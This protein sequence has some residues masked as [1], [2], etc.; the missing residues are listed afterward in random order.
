MLDLPPGDV[1]VWWADH[2]AAR[3]GWRDLLD[4][5]ER[6]RIAAYR[7][8]ADRD[9]FLVGVTLIRR[10]FAAELDLPPGRVSLDRACRHCGR[11]HGKVR[12]ARSSTA[13]TADA[14]GTAIEVSLSHSGAWVVLAA[15]RSYPVGVD[16]ETVDASIDHRAVAAIVLCESERR[17]LDATP[18]PEW[19]ASFARYWVRKEAVV[20]A[21]GEGL[22][23]PLADLEV[24][25]PHEAPRVVSWPS[26]PHLAGR[27][28]LYDLDTDDAH[29]A[30]LAVI[31]APV[32]R[33]V[34]R[35]VRELLPD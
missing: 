3:D 12:L 26:H 24:T 29:R 2:R 23:A 8:P 22:R 33:V 34:S 27:I 1:G 25:A 5:A 10:L 30:S 7:R 19:A 32:L 6:G 11:P 9:R 21:T 17:R 14:G 35:D 4:A 28:D 18:A 20:K 15:C 16:V 13:G 31:G